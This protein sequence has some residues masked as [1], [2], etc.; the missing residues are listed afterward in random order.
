[1]EEDTSSC[2]TRSRFGGG[3][4]RL[5][6]ED[7]CWRRQLLDEEAALGGG[8]WLLGESRLLDDEGGIFL[9][10]KGR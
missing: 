2:G 3:E 1:M 9:E 5:L 7:S 10:E 4:D 6:E 8:D